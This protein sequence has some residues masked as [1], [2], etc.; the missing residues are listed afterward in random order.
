VFQVSLLSDRYCIPIEK[1]K[2]RATNKYTETERQHR[3]VTVKDGK[4][5]LRIIIQGDATDFKVGDRVSV[6]NGKIIKGSG[7]TSLSPNLNPQ[8]EPPTSG[9]SIPVHK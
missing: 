6:E 9:V 5:K 4:G 7:G 8:L 1:V 2:S 3:K